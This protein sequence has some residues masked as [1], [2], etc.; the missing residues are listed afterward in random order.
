M[1]SAFLSTIKNGGEASSFYS[2][3]KGHLPQRGHSSD[4]IQMNDPTVIC[5]EKVLRRLLGVYVCIVNYIS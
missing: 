5:N 3:S 4:L 1:F 2:T